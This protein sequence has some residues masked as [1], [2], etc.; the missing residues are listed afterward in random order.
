MDAVRGSRILLV[1]DERA[2]AN[3]VAEALTDADW[4]VDHAGD[5]EEAFARVRSAYL[6]R[7]GL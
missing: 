4:Q 3:A 7:G 5:G 6:R 2:L 1:E